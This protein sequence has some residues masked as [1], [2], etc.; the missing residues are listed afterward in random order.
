MKKAMKI[1]FALLTS[2]SLI[3][4]SVSAGELTVT[5]TA[6][7]TYNILSGN[8]NLDKGMG[9]T[10]EIDF[11]A[12]GDLDNGWSW[13]Y[14]VQFDPNA[15]ATN[16]T[17]GLDD[18]RL[19]VTTGYGTV[20]F[21]QSEGGLEVVNKASQS[22]YARPTDIGLT[23]GIV[24][25]MNI[26]SY[27]NIQYHLPADLLPF[28]TSVKLAYAPDA[29]GNVI[30]GANTAGTVSDHLGENA[31][32]IQVTASPIEG[33]NVYADYYEEKGAGSVNN[34]VIQEAQS[35]G[36]AADY[37]I[38][39]FAFGVSKGRLAPLMLTTSAADKSYSSFV[40][41]GQ[42][43]AGVRDYR[44]T[45]MS[46]AFNVNDALTVSYEREQGKRNLIVQ[47]GGVSAH[48][49]EHDAYQA[50]YTMG[51]MTLALSYGKLQNAA[52]VK[53]SNID[54]TLLAMTMAF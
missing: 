41:G 42:T 3:S 20:G 27:N 10:N 25:S 28:S 38:G 33:L 40:G 11:G 23:S 52:W 51:G 37:S 32:Q 4:T 31:T 49:L 53:N 46:A 21:Y 44:N 14:Q 5:G 35:G 47:D 29:T 15:G 2:V 18:T 39:A 1:M 50:A 24:D 48:E 36:I 45:K 19:E 12:K 8:T 30:A 34:L 16:T 17:G 7:A 54:Q 13:N 9:L 22:A 26:G 6:K 43:A